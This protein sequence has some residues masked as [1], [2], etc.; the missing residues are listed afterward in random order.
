MEAGFRLPIVLHGK[1][2]GQRSKWDCHSERGLWWRRFLWTEPLRRI[3][4]RLVADSAGPRR[5]PRGEPRQR[6][7]LGCIFEQRRLPS[8][9][10]HRCTTS[11]RI[12]EFVPRR[13]KFAGQDLTGVSFRESWISAPDF[14][15]AIIQGAD[16]SVGDSYN[17]LNEFGQLG[18]LSP[19]GSGIAP[20]QFYSTASY[21]ARDLRG[22]NFTYNGLASASFAGQNLANSNFYR[23]ILTGADFSAANLTNTSFEWA[24]LTRSD[25]SGADAR[26][27]YG[28]NVWR[29]HHR[30]FD[31]TVISTASTSALAGCSS[32]ATTT[33]TPSKVRLGRHSGHRRPTPGDEPRRRATDGVRRGPMG[34]DDFFAPGIPVTLGGSV[35]S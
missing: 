35:G 28:L 21:R 7:F 20:A 12:S 33:A 32:C 2:S 3:L 19:A 25:F 26:G 13:A 18:G 24:T 23:A 15:G 30:L 5:L 8:N 22:I 11:S 9:A 6:H 16:F 34:F 4:R 17:Y 31:P 29:D 10:A 27:A 1:L 14:T